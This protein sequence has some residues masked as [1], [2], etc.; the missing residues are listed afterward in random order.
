MI[1][2]KWAKDIRKKT[3][4]KKKYQEGN[5]GGAKNHS[6][7]RCK[8][9]KTLKFPLESLLLVLMLMRMSPFCLTFIRHD[10]FNWMFGNRES[11]SIMCVFFVFSRRF[12]YHEKLFGFFPPSATPFNYTIEIYSFRMTPNLIRCVVSL[13]SSP[14]T[15]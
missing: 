9:K 8:Q 7:I 10:T 5:C 2:R 3:K 4:K 12:Y 14:K 15:P 1:L 11:F 13:S 6:R